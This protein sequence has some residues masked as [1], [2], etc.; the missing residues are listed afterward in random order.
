MQILDVSAEELDYVARLCLDPFMPPTWREAMQHAMDVRKEWLKNMMQKGLRILVALEKS[1]D[2]LRSFGARN[3]K[4]RELVIRDKV[5]KGL[6]EYAPI[7]SA[8]EPVKGGKSLF[9]NCVW[10]LSKFWNGGV[11]KSLMERFI[12]DAKAY[13]G[14]SV[15]AYEGDKWFGVFPY[16]PVSFFEKFGFKEVDR[17]GSRVLL[18]LNLGSDEQPRLIDAKTRKVGK[19]GKLVVDVLYSSQCPWSGWMADK[20]KRGIKK[21]G[22]VVNAI[23]TDDRAMIEEYGLSR[24]VCINGKPVIKRMASWKEIDSAV[25]EVIGH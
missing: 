13:G 6:I 9:V 5:P 1:D 23:N 17:D 3:R 19:S 11:A 8:P 20:V 25:K 14:A 18:H 16:M 10:V 22:A 12:E 15:L 24:G 4:I 2:V 7:E 21:Y